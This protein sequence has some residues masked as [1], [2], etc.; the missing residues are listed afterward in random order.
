M[1]LLVLLLC[2][3]KRGSKFC[4]LLQSF[5]QLLGQ[6]LEL[7]DGLLVGGFHTLVA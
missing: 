4:L 3:G 2:L 1:L 6:Q 5:V 7:L